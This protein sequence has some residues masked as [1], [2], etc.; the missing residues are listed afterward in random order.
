MPKNKHY[1]HDRRSNIYIALFQSIKHKAAFLCFFL[2]AFFVLK[3]ISAQTTLDRG[4][5]AIIGVNADNDCNSAPSQDV[6]S[7]VAFKDITNGTVLDI[8]D[9]GWERVFPNLWGDSEGT[10]RFTFNAGTITA[11]TTFQLIFDGDVNTTNSNN[12][13]WNVTD[14]NFSFGG[15][16]MNSSGDQIFVMQDGTWN[17]GGM[18]GDHDAT[19]SGRI[20]YGFNTRSVWQADGSSQQSNLHP[21]VDPCFHMEPT[22]GST[23]YISYSGPTAPATQLEWITLFG[24]PNNWTT[25]GSCASY[26]PPPASFTINSSGM[27]ID[28]SVCSGCGTVNSDLTFNLPASGGPFNVV[29]TDGTSEYTLNGI[30]DGYIESVVVN[31]TTTFEIVSVT[32]V[33]SCPVFSN[34]EGGATIT[35]GMGDAYAELSQSGPLCSGE[36]IDLEF[37]VTGSNPTFTID[38]FISIPPFLV[39]LPVTVPFIELDETWTVCAQGSGVTFNPSG[40]YIRIPE[41]YDG[42]VI[43]TLAGITDNVDCDGTVDPTPFNFSVIPTPTV[44]SAGPLQACDDGSGQANFDLTSLDN[45]INDNSG[46]PVN[47]FSDQQLNNPIGN[48][49]NYISGSTTV[50]A[51]VGGG[52][53]LSD[54]VAIELIVDPIPTANSA[55]D[56]VC[57]DVNGQ[58]TYDLTTLDVIVNGNS[59][60]PVNWYSDVNGNNPIP[61]P[62]SY[63]TNGG[64][65]YATV[66]NGI[67]ES[68]TSVVTLTVNPSPAA[69]PTSDELCDE[70]GGVATFDLTTL[71]NI[72][73]GSSGD[74][75]NWFSDS[76]ADNPINN[77]SNYVTTGGSVYAIVTDGVC[78]SSIVEI[79]LTVLPTPNANPTS[80]TECDD[81]NGMAIFNLTALDVIVNGNSGNPVSW[82]LDANGAFPIGTPSNFSSSGETVYASV[83]NGTCSSPLVEIILIVIESPVANG[84]T[85]S[86]CDDGNGTATFDLTSLDFIVNNGTSNTVNWYL[87]INGINPVPDPM[88][89]LSGNGTVYAQVAEGNCT[90]DIV[91]I[92]LSILS[93]PIANETSDTQCEENPG[94]ATFD[95]TTL[96]NIVNG[97]SGN[98]VSWFLDANGTAPIPNPDNY[99]SGSGIVYA[100]VSDGVCNSIAV[101]ITLIVIAAPQANPASAEECDDGNGTATFD[102]DDLENAVNGGNANLVNWFEDINGTMPISSPYTTGSTIVYATVE[103]GNCFSEIVEITLDVVDAPQANPASAEEC[104]DG[105]GTATFDLDD[106][107]NAVNGGNANLVNWFE[108]INGTMPISSPYTTGSTIVYATVGSGLCIS[109]IVEIM[110]NVVDAPQANSTSADECDDGNG[111][112]TFDLEALENTINGGNANPVN[113]FEDD[114]G[115]IPIFSPYTTGPTTIYATVGEGNC[116]SEIVEIVLNIVDSPQANPTSAQECD[117]GTGTASF[118][119]TALENIVNGGTANT[120]NWFE[121]D[122]GTIPISSPYTSPTAIVYATVG[123]G[124]CISQIVEITLNVIDSPDAAPA[125][126]SACD[127]GN[128]TAT[129][130]LTALENIVNTGTGNQVNWYQDPGTTISI[131]SPYV[132]SSTIV[133]ANVGSGNC[134]SITV[135]VQLTVIDAA[136]AIPTS[137]DEC[138]EGNGTATF[139]LTAL[140][141][142]VN[143]GTGAMVN[144]F[145]DDAGTTPISSPYS[146]VSTII[147]ATVSSGNCING[148]V[149]ITLNV[150]D[151]PEANSTSADECDIGNGTALFNLNALVS[152][153]N[154]S[155]G[156]PVNWYQDMAGTIPITS[157]YTTVSTTIYATVENGNCVSEIVAIQL[158]V[159]QNPD[160]APA[161]ASACDEGN[162]MATFNLTALESIV[163]TGTA[164]PVSW[165][166]N[167][168]ATIPINSPYVTSSTTVFAIVGTGN[169]TS[170][171]VGVQLTVLAAPA[172]NSAFADECDDG[173]GTANFDLSALESI[174]N[175]GTVNTVNWFEDINATIPISSPYST[176]STSIFATVEGV[177]CVSQIVEI[178]LNVLNI[179]QSN[180]AFV[181]QCDDGNGAAIFDLTL[182]EPTVNGGTTNQVNWFE[183]A[184][185]TIPITSP[186]NSA[187]TTIY[188]TVSNGNCISQI[189]EIQLNVDAS[190]DANPAFASECD[191]GNGTATFDLNNLESTV[192]GGSANTVI[193]F[194]DVNATIPIA[195][196]YTSV[197]T[198]IYANVTDGNCTSEIVEII[199][200]AINSP[201]ANPASASECDDGNGTSSFDLSL[202]E[203]TVN[204]GTANPVNWFEDVNATIPILSPYTSASTTIYANVGGGNCISGIAAIDLTI[205]QNPIDDYN[206]M[207]CEDENVT[208]NGTIYDV[209][210]PSGTEVFQNGANNGCDSIVFVDLDFFEPV[211][212]T[213][214]GETTICDGQSVVLTFNLNGANSYDI[215]YSDG[216]NPAILLNGINDGHTISVS[217]SVTTTYSLISVVGN[218]I[219]CSPTLPTSFVTVTV[220][221]IDAAVNILTDYQG[222][223]VSCNNE[224]DGAVEVTPQSGTAP[225]S[226]LWSNGA[227][228]STASNLS[229]GN[230]SVTVTDATGCTVEA[231]VTL[232]QPTAIEVTAFTT[233]PDCEDNFNGSIIIENI[234]GGAGIY[235]YSL[236]GQSF[237]P[238]L[239]FPVEIPFLPSGDY[240]LIVQ[241]INDCA[242][243]QNLFIQEPVAHFV[244]LGSDVEIVLG[245]SVQLNAEA[246]FEV[247]E[248]FWTPEENLSCLDCLDPIARP[249]ETTTYSVLVVDS[250]GCS[251]TDEITISVK[252][253]RNV[254]IPSAFSPNGDGTND[255]FYVFAGSNVVEIKQFSIFSRWGELIFNLNNIQPNDRNFAWNG[256]FNGQRLNP[257]VFIYLIEIEF[258]DGRTIIY[259]GDV[260]LMK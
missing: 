44:N 204:D 193:W 72:I 166:Q 150:L 116:I 35:I 179:P 85:D 108:D 243:S 102:L 124:N 136:P 25:Y 257:G 98:P 126:A 181:D 122:A 146:T 147:Y 222:F 251:A 185:A 220:S 236:E 87:D 172:A 203:S 93:I 57:G 110:L 134:I 75:V 49:S 66:S 32:D 184:N 67:C 142:I 23:E 226:Y 174:V 31:T 33:N 63:T 130:N 135:G 118:N 202:L 214:S 233:S 70:G 65:V 259:K 155:T 71:E 19:Y 198:T 177:N 227:T 99:M 34:F 61:N 252:K 52:P 10:F 14:I 41:D 253:S 217:P 167:A 242:T 4:D 223:A 239:A 244:N 56:E 232:S 148:P 88:N 78:E 30:N 245:E 82:F 1:Q 131:S 187:S 45:T 157:P 125:S 115:T 143:G 152:T 27:S 76:N 16:N 129:F 224:N 138:D 100:I 249:I 241:D 161:F 206:D 199:L 171:V 211:S 191:D 182:L 162:G 119:L 158:N 24:D 238:I 215:E 178:S 7:F 53:C 6:V 89:Y 149:E 197:S 84:T 74:L 11:G 164:N 234:I 68:E 92:L 205:L 133:Y 256:E 29:Y 194:E 235:E 39:D 213:I 48:P 151:S 26:I 113:W 180:N 58:T 40:N 237:T 28:C 128:G 230:Y 144:W 247:A 104:D 140:E 90:S 189:A 120:V 17:N 3:N 94:Q 51:N 12:P 255:N 132:T 21:E 54:S 107:E 209:N 64:V 221:S 73:N 159:G 192:N 186:Y 195:S 47:W 2:L 8:T 55:S 22:S 46:D 168:A 258:V 60:D 137:T 160:A 18:T 95:L 190:P 77:P 145:E 111:M 114:A 20:L 109:E 69:F 229:A 169:C 208:I 176:A 154:G 59:G 210:N 216:I 97:G 43:I 105:N 207:I 212:G 123:D 117:D 219:P 163:N 121:D 200:N 9:N 173:S 228:T 246:N 50:Y 96:D 81:G 248:I 188:A 165:Y 196:P 139:D 175:N 13:D 106:L 201:V 225:F 231:I 141:N 83:E 38:L 250:I 218:G 5:I 62:S 156:N 153:V 240:E 91:E 79:I 15:L 36:C 127:E 80:A 183:D 112:A 103:D 170:E 37:N 260:T 86:E 254:F 101:E 42:T